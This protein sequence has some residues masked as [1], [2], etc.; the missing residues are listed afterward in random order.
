MIEGMHLKAIISKL[1]W[2]W[3]KM[4]N[5]HSHSEMVLVA[6]IGQILNGSGDV[7]L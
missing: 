6:K 7:N 1:S 5:S 2:I 4:G 3:K